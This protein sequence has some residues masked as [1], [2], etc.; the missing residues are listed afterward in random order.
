M[1]KRVSLDWLEISVFPNNDQLRL[2]V[3]YFLSTFQAQPGS[4]SR[5]YDSSLVAL[6]GSILFYD[7][8]H[9]LKNSPLYLRFPGEF[10]QRADAE[11]I[12]D[13][14]IQIFQGLVV[15]FRFARI[16]ACIDLV[17][18]LFGDLEPTPVPQSFSDKHKI[19]TV[20]DADG[21]S[22]NLLFW[23]VRF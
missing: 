23:Q 22:R 10:F 21:F 11:E 20:C 2:I 17:S 6:N 19:K 13:G 16:D 3:D 18:Q 5:F 1:A 15:R 7:R 4:S 9:G 8:K 12:I 14:F